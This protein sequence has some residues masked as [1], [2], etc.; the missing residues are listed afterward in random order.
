M[1][2]WA[3]IRSMYRGSWTDNCSATCT[4]EACTPLDKTCPPEKPSGTW[5][6]VPNSGTK[7]CVNGRL[8]DQCTGGSW[9]D[10]CSATCTPEACTPLDKTC[11]DGTTGT[12]NAVPDSGTKQCV[13]GRLSDQCTGGSWI[14]NCDV[15]CGG[16]L[17]TLGYRC[18]DGVRK[19]KTECC[20]D[21]G[22]C[23]QCVVGVNG[24]GKCESQTTN[25]TAWS[26]TLSWN[27]ADYCSNKTQQQTRTRCQSGTSETEHQTVSGIK[28]CKVCESCLSNGRCGGDSSKA[29]TQPTG[30]NQTCKECDGSGSC[31]N[32][33]TGNCTPC[34]V[35]SCIPSNKMCS[36][37]TTVQ[38]PTGQ[39]T[40]KCNEIGQ[41]TN[42]CVYNGGWSPATCPAVSQCNS[43]EAC[44]GNTNGK[45]C[46]CMGDHQV[47]GSC[48]TSSTCRNL[49]PSYTCS[50]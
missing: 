20:S 48:E 16:R 21:C 1:C 25:W 29:G 5:N 22:T 10:N 9:T 26:P 36:D 8:S 39:G 15:L 38:S 30:C 44:S 50:N 47:H 6:A 27:I 32:K 12:W 23:K 4:P 41:P 43:G 24:F 49:G 19:P 42:E 7:Q 46:C 2:K 3:V 13:D 33:T 45:T 17:L 31:V 28:I 40:F 37:R 14:K 11:P 18:C 35:T 34:P